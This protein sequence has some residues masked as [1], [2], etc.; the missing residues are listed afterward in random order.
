MSKPEYKTRTPCLS[1]A[2]DFAG[3]RLEAGCPLT[4][5]SSPSPSLG[6]QGVCALCQL[7]QKC[8]CDGTV[9]HESYA[10]LRP[11]LSTATRCVASPTNCIPEGETRP[12]PALL[13]GRCPRRN[14]VPGPYIN[15]PFT[16]GAGK[17][18]TSRRFPD[19]KRGARGALP[20]PSPGPSSRASWASSSATCWRCQV[21]TSERIPSL[22][23]SQSLFQQN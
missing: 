15:F 20:V 1:R 9:C 2:S 12:S 5:M 18:N 8:S 7:A 21:K 22:R 19:A 23:K 17:T 6:L 14:P 16:A 10:H 3:E 13:A 11:T 4:A